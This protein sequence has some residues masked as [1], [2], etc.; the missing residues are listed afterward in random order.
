VT[1]RWAAL[2]V[3]APQGRPGDPVTLWA[4]WVSEVD[5]PAGVEPLDW[6][7]LTSVP[8]QSLGDAQERVAWYRVR[9]T[10]EIRQ[11]Q[12]PHTKGQRYVA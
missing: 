10:I 12:Y 2:T 11:P 1:L 3:P 4:V 5:A 6:L 9:W 7:L 8:V